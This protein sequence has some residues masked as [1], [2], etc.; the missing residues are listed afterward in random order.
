MDFAQYK[1]WQAEVLAERSPARFDCLNPFAAMD[2]FRR[3]RNP[4]GAGDPV[5]VFEDWSKVHGVARAAV[6]AV[7][8]RG[9]RSAL[10]HLFEAASHR[11]MD[12]V[13]PSDV[14]PFYIE[15]AHRRAPSSLVKTFPTWG[16]PLGTAWPEVG[17]SAL[18]LVPQPWNTFGRILAPDE[19][20]ALASWAAGGDDRWIVLDMVYLYASSVNPSLWAGL[21][22][23]RTIPLLSMS[24]SWLV[25][26]VF[27]G[28]L[29]L[30]GR[31]G[32]WSEGMP[33]PTEEASALAGAALQ[34]DPGFPE[35]QR[36]VFEREWA[37]RAHL[38][39]GIP[40]WPRGPGQGYFRPLKADARR[41]LEERNLLTVPASVF[42][43]VGWD[44]A[45]ATCLFE[46]GD[47]PFP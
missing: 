10:G 11:G 44:G 13:L 33:G 29:D 19:R 21:P 31:G 46:A 20:A 3:W 40:Q 22:P 43:H 24:K 47:R 17:R 16:A 15:E 7:P 27:G 9:V 45:V 23:D 14:Y 6:G 34:Q 4:G 37:R 38:L 36:R 42:G 28:A 8:T 25:R 41:L 26:G 2:S 35:R 30:T 18:L 1:V 12:L 5:R 39:D 32:W